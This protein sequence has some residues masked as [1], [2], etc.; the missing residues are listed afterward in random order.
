MG[1]YE[2][3]SVLPAGEDTF[4]I[5]REFLGNEHGYCCHIARVIAFGFMT[6]DEKRMSN[7]IAPVDGQGM[8]MCEDTLG[9][10]VVTVSG[11]DMSP[12]GR[13]WGEIYK[14]IVPTG[15]DRRELPQGVFDDQYDPVEWR[16]QTA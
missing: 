7:F 14:D 9:L 8:A 3:S 12:N 11:S 13:T 2:M 15:I 16:K 4:L 10:E 1:D 5:M 6:S